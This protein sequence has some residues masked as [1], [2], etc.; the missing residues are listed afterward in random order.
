MWWI[1]AEPAT[2]KAI[3]DQ[4]KKALNNQKGNNK[5]DAK[6]A[7]ESILAAQQRITKSVGKINGALISLERGRE[8]RIKTD[9]AKS[10][11]SGSSKSSYQDKKR[12]DN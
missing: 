6:S 10:Q 12:F 8:L 7:T 2:T 5:V 9:T 3:K 4:A 11:A 1:P